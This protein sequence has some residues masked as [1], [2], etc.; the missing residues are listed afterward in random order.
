MGRAG[1]GEP[2]ALQGG[3]EEGGPAWESGKASWRRGWLSQEP[4]REQSL[5]RKRTEEKCSG[6]KMTKHGLFGET[7]RLSVC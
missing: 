2:R 7:A 6:Q 5:A 1:T 4:K 3:P